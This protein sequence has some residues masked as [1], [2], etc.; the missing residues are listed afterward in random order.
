MAIRSPAVAGAFYPEDPT[1]LRDMIAKFLD[2]AEDIEIS[3][4]LCGLVEPHAGYIYSGPTAAYGYKLL[5][6]YSRE[7]K[8]VILLGPSHFAAFFG[9]AESDA[10]IWRTPLGDVEIGKLSEKAKNK[11]LFSLHPAA[12][13]PEHCLEVQLPFIQTVLADF[14]LYP[15]L[16]SDIS[17]DTLANEIARQFDEH[18]VV[19]ASSDLS[20]YHQYDVAKKRDHVANETV[21]ALNINKFETSGDAC[22]KTAILTL[23]YL[24]KK[25]KWKGTFLDYKNSGDTAGPK[26]GVVGY[27]CYA[28]YK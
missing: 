27:G 25:L 17:P 3:D 19:I 11:E 4:R 26:D 21:P 28:F 9:A 7:I 15:L 1:D 5:S 14:T 13:G 18:T 16:V 20:H 24:A 10:E 2:D 6:K 22:G 12:H 23:M 8:K